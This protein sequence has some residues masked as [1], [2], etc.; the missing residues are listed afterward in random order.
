MPKHTNSQISKNFLE[1]GAPVGN[2]K[3]FKHHAVDLPQSSLNFLSA[4]RQ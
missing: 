2:V 1:K 4:S 3:D